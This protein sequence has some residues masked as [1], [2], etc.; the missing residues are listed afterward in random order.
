MTLVYCTETL[1]RAVC[2][3]TRA[4]SADRCRPQGSLGRLFPLL[5][6]SLPPPPPE[7][8]PQPDLFTAF[9]P[10]KIATAR[11]LAGAAAGEAPLLS[12][13]PPPPPPSL[14]RARIAAAFRMLALD[15][16]RGYIRAHSRAGFRNLHPTPTLWKPIEWRPHRNASE[17]PLCAVWWLPFVKWTVL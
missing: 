5:A 11:C 8:A 4:V 3:P 15:R 9:V 13:A 12:A 10:A 7:P 16:T 6:L 2:W 14:S 17:G 1:M